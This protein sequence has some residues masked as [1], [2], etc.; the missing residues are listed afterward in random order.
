MTRA[1]PIKQHARDAD[2]TAAITLVTICMYMAPVT[3]PFAGLAISLSL[4]MSTWL[5]WGGMPK[6][7]RI[8]K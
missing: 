6:R 2:V 8:K 3:A 5:R 1:M 7:K 4:Q